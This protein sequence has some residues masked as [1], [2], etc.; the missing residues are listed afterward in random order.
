M[1]RAVIFDLDGTLLDTIGDLAG[2]LNH[3]LRKHGLPTHKNESV[4]GFIGDGVAKLVARAIDGGEAHPAFS[5]VLADFRAYYAAHMTDLTCPFAGIDTLLS[6]LLE[7]D[8]GIAVVSNKYDAAVKALTARFFGELISLAIGE[9]ENVK[10]K[11][12]P[13]ALLYAMRVLDADPHVTYYVGDSE[14]DILTARN[15]GIPCLSVTWGFRSREVLTSA[16]ATRLFD[17]PEAL[18]S[19]LTENPEA[20]A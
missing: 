10:R 7:A 20:S 16:G 13:D 18:L 5:S 19:F 2:A 17:T 4:L 11:P 1:K 15:A 12:S 8:I 14:V 6:R 3:A 9:S